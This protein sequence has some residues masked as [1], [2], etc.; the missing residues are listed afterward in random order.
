MISTCI[1]LFWFTL[2]S[3]KKTKMIYI[4]LSKNK[5]NIKKK[6]LLE[7]GLIVNNTH[8]LRLQIRIV[9]SRSE[10]R[11]PLTTNKEASMIVKSSRPGLG[12]MFDGAVEAT[13]FLCSCTFK[14]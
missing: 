2:L 12:V 11:K 5:K 8:I 10:I 4:L 13:V 14:N 3:P 9:H 1:C 7:I 6:L